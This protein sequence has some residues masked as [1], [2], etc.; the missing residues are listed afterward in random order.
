MILDTLDRA[1][2]YRSLGSRFAAGLEWLKKF[3]VSTPDG[4]YD[5]D[6]N[7]VYALVQSYDT[8]PTAEKRYESHRSF[9]DIQ[10]VADGSEV[11]HYAPT[12]GLASV[13][14]YDAQKDFE[15][16]ADPTAS[17]LLHLAPGMFAIFY[18]QDGHKPGCTNGAQ[19]RMKKVVIKVRL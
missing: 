9:A 2:T 11:I 17:T 16:Y 12:D 7:D 15:L 5:I 18:P 1:A 10:F 6:H 19:C 3:Q 8:V 4:R 14:S 13:A